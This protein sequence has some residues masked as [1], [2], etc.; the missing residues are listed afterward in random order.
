MYEY[1]NRKNQFGKE[2]LEIFSSKSSIIQLKGVSIKFI[3]DLRLYKISKILF[4]LLYSNFSKSFLLIISKIISFTFIAFYQILNYLNFFI[5]L[6]SISSIYSLIF[7]I[8]FKI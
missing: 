2:Y 5:N 6:L 1:I 7:L 4:I 3:I 8:N